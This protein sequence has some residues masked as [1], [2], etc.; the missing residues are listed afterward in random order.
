MGIV[1]EEKERRE[2]E[3]VVGD[4]GRCVA[5]GFVRTTLKVKVGDRCLPGWM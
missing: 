2:T 4:P 1:A 3:K 5:F